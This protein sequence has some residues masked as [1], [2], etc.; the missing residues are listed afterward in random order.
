MSVEI[1]GAVSGVEAEVD[2][3]RSLQMVEYDQDGNPVIAAPNSVYSVAIDMRLTAAI[4]AGNVV[5][6][7]TNTGTENV[8]IRKIFGQ[9]GFAGTAAA[10]ASQWTVRRITGGTPTGGTAVNPAPFDS[11]YPVSSVGDIRYIVNAGLTMGSAVAGDPLAAFMCGRQLNVGYSDVL[12]FEGFDRI[13]LAPG[14][15]LVLYLDV[16]S[17]IGDFFAGAIEWEEFTP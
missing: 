3:H 17:V 9:T 6:A 12:E 1:V 16:V 11:T 7:M 8:Y 15:G 4:A 5:W 2:V 13:L 10:T 14:E